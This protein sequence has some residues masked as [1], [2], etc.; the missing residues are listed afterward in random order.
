[1][2]STPRCVAIR[3]LRDFRCHGGCQARVGE[4]NGGGSSAADGSGCHLVGSQPR[5]TVLRMQPRRS[6][7]K[8]RVAVG[9]PVPPRSAT[10]S[11]RLPGGS[12]N[13]C[14][15][16]G[17][18]PVGASAVRV[19]VQ[20]LVVRGLDGGD[21]PGLRLLSADWG[22]PVALMPYPAQHLVTEG[23]G[24]PSVVPAMSDNEGIVGQL[25]AG[26]GRTMTPDRQRGT[27][28]PGLSRP[29]R[30]EAG[31]V[32]MPKDKGSA[33]PM[34]QCKNATLY[35]LTRTPNRTT[36]PRQSLQE[37][38]NH[39]RTMKPQCPRAASQSSRT[40]P[41]LIR[42]RYDRITHDNTAVRP[43]PLIQP[44]KLQRLEFRAHA[45]L[46]TPGETE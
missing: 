22:R 32:C 42:Q 24:P 26:L 29:R 2:A 36:A 19:E 1:M 12:G 18:A 23:G 13:A 46:H 15:N 31:F 43:E 35:C 28:S 37:P 16:S 44:E 17:F 27:E 20:C 38:L 11:S 5:L 7:G 14:G 41:T 25:G 9:I 33:S 45:N 21:S 39:S 3:S 40:S 6:P 4:F 10:H 8:R 34:T 30:A